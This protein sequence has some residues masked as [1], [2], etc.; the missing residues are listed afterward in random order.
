M[1]IVKEGL[2]IKARATILANEALLAQL[3]MLQVF[4]PLPGWLVIKSTGDQA[5]SAAAI[6]IFDALAPDSLEFLLHESRQGGRLIEGF[7][8]RVINDAE[9]QLLGE[10]LPGDEALYLVMAALVEPGG[11]NVGRMLG[12]APE[13]S[14]SGLIT[15][16]NNITLCIQAMALTVALQAELDV[17]EQLV[18]DMQRDAFL[19]PLT[20]V[21]NR[22][23]WIDR[24]GQ[25]DQV[26]AGSDEDAAVVMLDLD[27]LKVVNDTD[28]HAAGDNMLC[29]TARTI[30]TVLRNSDSVGRLGGDEF[31]IVIQRASLAV[32]QSL[33]GRLKQALAQG[34]V[35]ISM[36]MAM[37]SESGSLKQAMHLADHRM[38]MEKRKNRLR[39]VYEQR[40]ALLPLWLATTA[41]PD[42]GYKPGVPLRPYFVPLLK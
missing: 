32:A 39:P 29:L 9:R 17:A 35:K 27:F 21:L 30:S 16:S 36:G 7:Y 22:A 14:L 33:L 40:M 18:V 24:L 26:T 12:L 25:I 3:N 23:G 37:K 38:Y 6:G 4:L 11:R 34:G 1:S 31:G 20:G 28:G 2:G 8:Y 41:S 10:H 19:D 5:G 42:A 13:S 15:G